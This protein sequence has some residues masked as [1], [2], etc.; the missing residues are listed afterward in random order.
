MKRSILHLVGAT[1]LLTAIA[2]T[3]FQPKP[4]T[5]S[6]AAESQPSERTSTPRIAPSRG[7]AKKSPR[8]VFESP[9]LKISD[10]RY[11]TVLART[12]ADLKV[13]LQSAYSLPSSAVRDKSISLILGKLAKH[14]PDL[15]IEEWLKW[16]HALT[17]PWLAAASEICLALGKD[18]PFGPADFINQHIPKPVRFRVWRPLLA[19]MEEHAVTRVLAS[20]PT[21]RESL[22]FTHHFTQQWL[23]SNPEEALE[24]LDSFLPTLTRPQAKILGEQYFGPFAPQPFLTAYRKAS[25]PATRDYLAKAALSSRWKDQKQKKEFLAEVS[26]PPSESSAPEEP[27]YTDSVKFAASLSPA[28]YKNLTQKE[29]YALISDLELRH[30]KDAASALASLEISTPLASTLIRWHSFEPRE[31]IAFAQELPDTKSNQLALFNFANSTA[32]WKNQQ[33]TEALL[34]LLTIP[35]YKKEIRAE[36]AK[37]NK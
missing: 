11:T 24:W 30:P 8:P 15:A 1:F 2:L 35:Q 14:N 4:E 20:F 3:W 22:M 5:S 21:T 34:N 36:L 17:E 18:D 13:A 29:R 28:D 33:D 12:E 10:P 16:E 26:P 6:A 9:E 31:A 32:H 19:T 25:Q 37:I 27:L 23:T 7:T